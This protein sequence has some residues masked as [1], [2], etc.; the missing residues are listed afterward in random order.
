MTLT[1]MVPAFMHIHAHVVQCI[2]TI[3]LH[4][5]SFFNYLHLKCIHTS[6]PVKFG[7]TPP[8]NV[9]QIIP[10]FSFQNVGL[11]TKQQNLCS[12]MLIHFSIAG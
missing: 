5:C 8:A 10:N 6:L 12:T 3:Q 9:L 4:L 7:Y 2:N 11:K 1:T